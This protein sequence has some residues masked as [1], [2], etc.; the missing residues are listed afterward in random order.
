MS[1]CSDDVVGRGSALGVAA[2]TS[3]LGQN[4]RLSVLNWDKLSFI[5]YAIKYTG[6]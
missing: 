1:C 5:M 2:K 3:R 6:A 4:T